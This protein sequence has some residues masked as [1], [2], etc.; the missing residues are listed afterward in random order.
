M[1]NTMESPQGQILR[2]ATK[3]NLPYEEITDGYHTFKELYEFRKMYNAALFNE[4]GK[5]KPRVDDLN[6]GNIN[7]VF[8]YNNPKSKLDY[9]LYNVHKS[10][11]HY[12]GDLCFGGG[13]FIVV[14]ML[15]TGQ[16]TNHYK[17]EDWDLFKIP[18]VDKALFP[19]DGHTGQDVLERLKNL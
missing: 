5:I 19:F 10:W 12:D 6:N 8:E 16:I 11:K 14:A 9:V 2:L 4:W 18:E 1:E 17:A 15:P 13:W 3:L 7:V